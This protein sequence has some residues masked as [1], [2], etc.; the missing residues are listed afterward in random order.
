MRTFLLP[1]AFFIMCVVP[2]PAQA[3]LL[4]HG[5]GVT[6]SSEGGGQALD[7]SGALCSN[8]VFDP[9]QDDIVLTLSNGDF[10]PFYSVEI[11]AGWLEK[12]GEGLDYQLT[13]AGAAASTL[14]AVQLTLGEN[15]S[16]WTINLSA[17]EDDLDLSGTSFLCFS[18]RIGDDAGAGC[19]SMD[20]QGNGWVTVEAGAEKEKKVALKKEEKTETK[21]S[22]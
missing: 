22:S 16:T 19:L 15:L 21:P 13:P 3:N 18:L 1:V 7:F 9:L 12:A 6:V 10:V 2:N 11:P 4:M 5:A 17:L 14:N 20:Y 8:G